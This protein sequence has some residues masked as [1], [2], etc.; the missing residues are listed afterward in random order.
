[1]FIHFLHHQTLNLNRVEERVR[2]RTRLIEKI[3]A[4]LRWAVL[5][6]T[7]ALIIPSSDLVQSPLVVDLMDELQ[8]LTTEGI[9]LFVGSSAAPEVLQEQHRAQF[10]STT[11]QQEWE[12]E[13]VWR[14][15]NRFASSFHGRKHNT[16][17]DMGDAW[18][19]NLAA[20]GS[21]CEA[22]LGLSADQLVQAYKVLRLSVTP[23]E[24]EEALAIIPD[25]LENRAFLWRIVEHFKLFDHQ[26]SPQAREH[27]EMALA[28]DWMMSYITEYKTKIIGFV[29]GIGWI[30]CGLRESHPDLS[31]DLGRYERAASQ[32]GLLTAFHQLSLAE[33]IA[34]RDQPRVL[35]LR[36]AF[37]LP[38]ANLYVG[39][40]EGDLLQ[41]AKFHNALG[42]I[43]DGVL[44]AQDAYGA[45]TAAADR[46]AQWVGNEERMLHGVRE[47]EA[48]RDRVSD[49]SMAVDALRP[50]GLQRGGTERSQNMK[51]KGKVDFAV[52]TVREDEFAAVLKRFPTYRPE[53][54]YRCE[55]RRYSLHSVPLG[56]GGEYLVAVGC[57]IEQGPGHANDFARDMIE[58]LDPHYVV[59]VGIAGAVP[60]TEFT[61][62]DVV[63][64]KRLHD[65]SVGAVIQDK[66]R[67]TADQGGPMVKEVQDLLAFLPALNQQ[68]KGWNVGKGIPKS[69]PPVVLDSDNFYGGPDW[70]DKVR[71]AL[72][73]HFGSGAKVRRPKYTARSIASSG[74][75]IKDASILGQWLAHAR[76]TS[77][78]EMELSGV[79]T[80]CRRNGRDYPILAVRGISDVVGFRRDPQWTAYACK[81]AAAFAYALLRASSIP[82]RS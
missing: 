46:V 45:V 55:N 62:G 9:A 14:R 18:R 70:E 39:S 27:F 69:R 13:S 59:L 75:L 25:R 43:R 44:N 68:L 11:L 36:D 12:R 37:L 3:R 78:V 60:D 10:E 33:V 51:Y 17:S 57:S 74:D 80:A 7:D 8:L 76:E 20:L 19:N 16:T 67:E 56:D 4:A 29:P 15:L 41:I 65:F 24:F 79:Y 38:L 52:L 6:T 54:H 40:G 81:T 73:F 82:P 28:W 42:F 21:N 30:D 31:I 53:P 1:M 26:T 77:V 50:V 63:V 64:A 58:D 23:S 5:L 34:L 32:I 66:N 22:P 48:G 2:P 35:L 61:L 49:T 47:G 71:T 72:T